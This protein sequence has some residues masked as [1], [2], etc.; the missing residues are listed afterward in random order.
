M[1][2]AAAAAAALA[3]DLAQVH[4][5]LQVKL[6]ADPYGQMENRRALFLAD[7]VTAAQVAADALGVSVIQRINALWRNQ[8]TSLRAIFLTDP[9]RQVIGA[10]NFVPFVHPPAPPPFG[11]AAS[12][13]LVNSAMQD[14][15]LV[16]RFFYQITLLHTVR[17][18]IIALFSPSDRSFESR[19]SCS[20]AM[21]RVLDALVSVL[22]ATAVMVQ[23][24]HRYFRHPPPAFQ[25]PKYY[26]SDLANNMAA[27]AGVPA[28]H[29]PRGAALPNL[30]NRVQAIAHAAEGPYV[31]RVNGGVVE[32]GPTTLFKLW[33]SIKHNQTC[34]IGITQCERYILPG[35]VLAGMPPMY[36]LVAHLNDSFGNLEVAPRLAQFWNATVA[37]FL[38]L[39]DR[40][41][42]AA[43]HARL[44]QLIVHDGY[45]FK[46]VNFTHNHATL[47]L[48]DPTPAMA[49]LP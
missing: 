9:V 3:R 17:N 45:A 5:L 13:K 29:A 27:V 12:T 8:A 36:Q 38:H 20:M 14:R 11:V 41:L 43:E 16:G 34:Q 46:F 47:R 31:F 2:A 18:D 25:S 10:P 24:Q 35:P 1:A 33:N 15:D 39:P 32:R 30:W 7:G 26:F 22:D 21:R 44:L 49:L 4:V 48:E 37:W 40:L 42:D 6:I 19:S 28:A 23:Q